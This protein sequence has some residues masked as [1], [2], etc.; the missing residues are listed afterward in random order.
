MK[1]TYMS[2]SVLV[3]IT[4]AAIM[5][6]SAAGMASAASTKVSGPWNYT[7]TTTAGKTSWSAYILQ[8]GPVLVGKATL[9]G[10]CTANVNGSISGAKFKITWLCPGETVNLRGSV[11]S[12]KLIGTFTDSKRGTGTFSAKPGSNED[13]GSGD[14]GG[15]GGGGGGDS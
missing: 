10:G 15:E 8:V 13:D 2:R 1:R 11:K 12:K 4:G 5:S 9:K 7:L 14:G 6:I 3:A